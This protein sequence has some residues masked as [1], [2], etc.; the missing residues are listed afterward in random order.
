[1]DLFIKLNNGLSYVNKNLLLFV[2]R[3][4]FKFLE[5]LKVVCF[6]LIVVKIC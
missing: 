3:P 1:M 5:L 2:I 6:P 4:F